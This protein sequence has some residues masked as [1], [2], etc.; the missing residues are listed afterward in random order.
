MKYIFLLTAFV[1]VLL[2]LEAREIKPMAYQLL[3]IGEVTPQGWLHELMLRQRDGLTGKMDIV[4]PQVMGQRNGWLGGDGDQWER[5]P[6]WI[7]GLLTMAYML[8]D[9]TLQKKV[10]PWVEWS[11]THQRADGFFGPDKDYPSEWGLQRNNALDWWPRMV[12]LKIMRDYYEA[13]SDKRVITFLQ[14]YFKY[15]LKTLPEKPLGTWTFWGQ[16]RECDN[17]SVVLWLYDITHDDFLLDLADLLH[18]QGFD[19]TTFFE[20]ETVSKP[21]SIHCVNLAQGLKEPIVYWRCNPQERF[22]AAVEKG[23][24][25][26]RRFNGFP[27]GMYGG[28]EALHGNNPLN[29][30]ELCSAVELMY[31]MEEMARTTGKCSFADYLERVAYNALPTQITDDFMGKQYYQQVNQ[32][33]VKS[34]YGHNFDQKQDGTGI[35]FGI[36]SGYPCC[37]SNFHQ[38]WPKFVRN[39]WLKNRKGGLTALIYGP[40]SVTTNIN[41]KVVTVKEE[42]M[43]P[44]DEKIVMTVK[45]KGSS[46]LQFPLEMRIPEWCSSPTLKVNDQTYNIDSGTGLFTIDRI[47]K[48][49]DKVEI[50]FPMEIKT[51]RW[52]E[53]SL[54]VERGPLVYALRIEE[55]WVKKYYDDNL[56]KAHGDFAWEVYPKTAWNY[57]ILESKN[58][59]EMFDFKVDETKLHSGIYPWS[60]EG[61]PVEIHA[62]AKEV[63][64]WKL[65]DEHEAG[66]LPFSPIRGLQTP[67]T[68]IRLIPYGCTTLRI[69]EFPTTK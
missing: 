16:M 18:K 7:D 60:L 54:S 65:Y 53:N 56:K 23:L 36:L 48:T 12:M 39:L 61:S 49:G 55:N 8:H 47:W 34:G 26:I 20:E 59:N 41:G 32:V 2:S 62:K 4:Y 40:S 22:I 58:M 14:N 45:V 37:L 3:P 10:Q 57:A 1:F 11:L 21:R 28:D 6:Y 24:N 30:S 67:V 19:Y 17:L 64:F 13:T 27:N 31:S 38:G 44:F 15:Q 35:D 46:S 5:G 43:Y 42:T 66:V 9:K 50:S 69:A 51:S 52:Y 68:T 33:I 63:P 29:G 25:D